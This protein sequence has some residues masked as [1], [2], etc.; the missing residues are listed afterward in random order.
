[1]SGKNFGKNKL[2]LKLPPGAI[3]TNDHAGND[4]SNE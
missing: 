2:N 1:M 4:N 3:E